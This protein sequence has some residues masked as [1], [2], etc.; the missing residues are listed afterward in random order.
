MSILRRCRFSLEGTAKFDTFIER[1]KE[2]IATLRN[3]CSELQAIQLERSLPDHV[4]SNRDPDKLRAVSRIYG[5]EAERRRKAGQH[6]QG[7][8]LIRDIAAF[9]ASA[10]QLVKRRRTALQQDEMLNEKSFLLSGEYLN[11]DNFDFKESP[12]ETGSTQIALAKDK[13]AQKTRYIEWKPYAYEV[14]TETDDFDFKTKRIKDKKAEDDI[15]ALSDFFNVKDRPAAFRI[16][17]FLGI[18]RDDRRERFGL[19]YAH[20]ESVEDLE[21]HRSIGDHIPMSL[22]EK[23]NKDS[24]SP[25]PLVWPL[26]D[27]FKL[28]STVA[29][30]LYV[31][32]AA[33]WVHKNIRSSSFTFFPHRSRSASNAQYMTKPYLCGFGHSRP[34]QQEPSKQDP[35]PGISPPRSKTYWNITL[36]EYHHPAKRVDSLLEYTQAFDLYSLGVVLLE[37][38]LWQ[39]LSSFRA[40]RNLTNDPYVSHEHLLK[41]ARQE[42]PGQVGKLYAEVVTTCLKVS[43][44]ESDTKVQELLCWKVA[45][46]LDACNA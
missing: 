21:G 42:L 8:E 3:I 33:G 11:V 37:I 32:H 15:M 25:K 27:R 46:A 40:T 45:A 16:L 43:R 1:L 39:P 31:L 14:I 2:F 19:V 34:G 6:T 17:P 28:A 7:P 24:Q 26:G 12:S 41:I 44:D 20:P 5:E 18:F 29:Q 10:Q 36:D 38:G 30:C 22:L 13:T 23:V 4:S 9:K 35:H